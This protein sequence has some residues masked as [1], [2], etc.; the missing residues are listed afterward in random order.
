M[1]QLL[2]PRLSAFS[3]GN[4][5]VMRLVDKPHPM[6]SLAALLP[7]FFL[8]WFPPLSF[9]Q[10]VKSAKASKDHENHPVPQTRSR[11]FY[12]AP[13]CLCFLCFHLHILLLF[14]VI[15]SFVS[16][17]FC[18]PLSSVPFSSKKTWTTLVVLPA[19][20]CK[21]GQR[22]QV[23]WEGRRV[24]WAIALLPELLASWY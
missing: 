7:S 22:T 8:V 5:L 1:R 3:K 15:I 24:P 11:E 12:P 14:S 9:S 6:V 20:S 16:C 13:F 18:L 23:P 19:G 21:Y 10:K 2:R 4:M 17:K